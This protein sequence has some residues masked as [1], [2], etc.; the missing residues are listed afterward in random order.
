MRY[1]Y[2]LEGNRIE[3]TE[4]CTAYDAP[5]N[6]PERMKLVVKTGK[7]RVWHFAYPSKCPRNDKWC[8]PMSLFHK[9]WARPVRERLPRD[10][11]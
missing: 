1:G 3:A 8:K 5:S 7:E 11:V 10:L 9:S 4:G 6:D 2:D